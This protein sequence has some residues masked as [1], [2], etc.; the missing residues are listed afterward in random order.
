MKDLHKI[1][2]RNYY[3]K[4]FQRNMGL[5]SQSF[6]LGTDFLGAKT[7]FTIYY[8]VMEHYLCCET[9]GKS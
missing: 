5:S 2:P 3:V 4:P 6:L 9:K 1:F 7:G 8:V